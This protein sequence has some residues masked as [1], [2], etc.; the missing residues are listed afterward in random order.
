MRKNNDKRAIIAQ[1]VL[2]DGSGSVG[3]VN[4]CKNGVIRGVK[5]A[6]RKIK[7]KKLAIE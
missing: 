2:A 6:K 3:G 7:S 5:A 1:G 4:M